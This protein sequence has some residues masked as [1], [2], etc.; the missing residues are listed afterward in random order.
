M[1]FGRVA[2]ISEEFCFDESCFDGVRVVGV[3]VEVV[4]FVKSFLVCFEVDF[5]MG[6][7]VRASE[8]VKV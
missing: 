6:M 8:K 3:V 1:F 2:E 7:V 4:V 5:I